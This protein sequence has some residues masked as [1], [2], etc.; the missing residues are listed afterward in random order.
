L[1][2]VAEQLVW[3]RPAEIVAQEEVVQPHKAKEDDD[4][5]DPSAALH[6]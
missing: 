4:G 1:K 3:K 5:K 6:P 2:I